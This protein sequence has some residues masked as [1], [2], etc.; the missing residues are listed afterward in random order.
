[1]LLNI[2][3]LGLGEPGESEQVG[4]LL[5]RRR[6]K[7]LLQMPSRLLV[8]HI[9]A[10]AQLVVGNAADH[11]HGAPVV[12]SVH[13]HVGAIVDEPLSVPGHICNRNDPKASQFGQLEGEN[14]RG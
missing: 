11:V 13:K 7:N 8:S 10:E 9:D 1:M 14:P 12:E 2:N 4:T 6:V 3:H 5:G